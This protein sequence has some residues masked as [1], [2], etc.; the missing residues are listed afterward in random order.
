MQTTGRLDRGDGTELAWIKRVT[1]Q[2]DIWHKNHLIV[3]NELQLALPVR[4][5]VLPS[6]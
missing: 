3:S 5:C 1:R 4:F 2:F 6:L